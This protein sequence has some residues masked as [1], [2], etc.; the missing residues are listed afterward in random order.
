MH[1]AILLYPTC[2]VIVT[3]PTLWLVIMPSFTDT[4][5]SSEELHFTLKISFVFSGYKTKSNLLWLLF[6]IDINEFFIEIPRRLINLYSSKSI[7]F[8]IAYLCA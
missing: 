7:L 2:A 6:S 1:F 4:I 8:A 5:F 3:I